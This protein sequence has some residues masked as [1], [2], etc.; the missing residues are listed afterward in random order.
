MLGGVHVSLLPEEGLRHADLVVRGEGEQSL[1]S[2][3]REDLRSGVVESQ[4]VPDLDS[5]PPPAR[6]LLRMEF[7]LR[8]R[9]RIPESYL[10]F[11]PPEARVAAMLTSRGCPFDCLFCHNSWRDTPFRFNSAERVV[12]EVKEL[13]AKHAIDALFFIEDNLFA[14]K[15]RLR[16]ICALFE[17]EGITIP[18]GGNARVSDLDADL[19][20]VV[21]KAGCRQ[22][23]FGF[24]SGSQRILD[25]LRKRTTVEQNRRAVALCREAGIIPQ[26]TVILGSPTETVEEIRATQAFIRDSRLES[27]GV[28]LATPYPGTGLWKL[29]EQQ[30]KIP[31]NLD[32]SDFVYDRVPIRVNDVIP[33]DVLQALFAETQAIALGNRP[34]EPLVFSRLVR[35]FRRAPGPFLRRLAAL[36]FDPHRWKRLLR[37]I[38]ATAHRPS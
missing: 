7:Y 8:S 5:L 10:H 30:G 20:A 19:L 32:W 25:L 33:P 15:D 2:I 31:A 21:R 28:C 29:C 23:T 6:H 3:V 17:A 22:I 11:V 9:Q 16:R 27:V 13:I 14:R 26:G 37:R 24:E 36:P 35:E 1:L 4:P 12:R 38:A 34:P 18:W